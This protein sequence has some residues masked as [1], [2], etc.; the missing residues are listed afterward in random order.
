MFLFKK[1][2]QPQPPTGEPSAVKRLFQVILRRWAA[3]LSSYEQKM[4][5]PA[6]KVAIT[7]FCLIAGILAMNTLYNGL[8]LP[9]KAPSYLNRP[10]KSRPTILRLPDSVARRSP[11]A[12]SNT[13]PVLPTHRDSITK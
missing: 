8:F 1:K 6:K 12:D 2:S 9:A 4:S 7:S 13:P 5:L 10:A 11:S 3:K